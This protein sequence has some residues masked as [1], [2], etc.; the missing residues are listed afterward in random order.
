[1]PHSLKI[2]YIGLGLM[3][4]SIAHNILKTGFPL[5]VHNRS[6]AAVTELVNEGAH[7]APSPAEVAAQVEVVF[8]NLPDTPDVES[9]ALGENGI[10]HGA[11]S[12]LIYVDNYTI[13]PA[14]A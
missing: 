13:K 5:V 4:K 9:F 6:Q 14:I 2:G 10:I 7:S 11:H 3:G 1:M 8:T 12:G